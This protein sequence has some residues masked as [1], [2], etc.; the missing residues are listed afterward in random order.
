MWEKIKEVTDAGWDFSIQARGRIRYLTFKRGD[1]RVQRNT[2]TE[3]L[4]LALNELIEK[5]KAF[6]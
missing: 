5:V 2:L 6:G 4:E 3:E 1:I